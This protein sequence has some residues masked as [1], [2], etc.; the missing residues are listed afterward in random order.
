MNLKDKRKIYE[1]CGILIILV[2]AISIVYDPITRNIKFHPKDHGAMWNIHYA[3]LSKPVIIGDA[4][5]ISNPKMSYTN[6]GNYS[7]ALSKPGD[8][9][10][11]EFDIV[12]DGTFDA[13]INYYNEY[14]DLCYAYYGETHCDWNGNGHDEIEDI[15]SINKNISYT[16][17]Y[18]KTKKSV[19]V[20]DELKRHSKRHVILTIK[21]NEDSTEMPEG[22]VI[23]NGLDKYINYSQK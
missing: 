15:V 19:K 16:L 10:I 3:N 6:I 20:G 5:V 22:V 12:N 21:F 11:Y 7:V 4:R 8:A 13:F 17:K 14:N 9:I 18:S 2:I 23:L 1:I